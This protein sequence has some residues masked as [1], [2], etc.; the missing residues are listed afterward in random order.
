MRCVAL[1]ALACLGACGGETADPCADVEGTCLAVRVTSAIVDEIDQL[2]LDILYGDDHDTITTEAAGVVGLPVAT[3]IALDDA[4]ASLEVGVVAAGR[5]SGAVLGT[6]AASTTVAPGEHAAIAI[7]LNAVA[8][9]QDG[10]RY[11]GGDQIAGDPDTLYVCDAGSVPQAR[12]RCVHGCEVS[13]SADDFCAGGPETCTDGGFYCGGN[14]VDGDPGTRYTCS[15]GAGT[16]PVEC[17]DGC[18]VM[19]AGTDDE[20][21]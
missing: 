2:Q 5:L 13:P 15:A 21:R 8:V 11:C 17:P 16:A 12:G 3:A 20:C 19:P 7:Q 1:A 9:C 4:T 18:V 14:E 10:G 6:G